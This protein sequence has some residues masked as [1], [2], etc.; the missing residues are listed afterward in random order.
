VDERK[1][2]GEIKSENK[3]V[4]TEGAREGKVDK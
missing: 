2:K 4:I 3:G 1:E